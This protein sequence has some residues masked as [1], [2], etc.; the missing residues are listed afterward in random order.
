MTTTRTERGGPSPSQR[1]DSGQR[2][3]LSAVPPAELRPGPHGRAVELFDPVRQAV[4][5]QA[6]AA[7][8]IVGRA[9]R[10]AG[11][12][13]ATAYRLKERSPAFAEAWAEALTASVDDLEHVALERARDGSDSVLLRVLEAHRPERYSRKLDVKHAGT[14]DFV[15]DLVPMPASAD[16]GGDVLDTEAEVVGPGE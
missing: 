13:T 12:N 8:P 2:T 9:C 1:D 4:F 14:V 11:I 6:L 5:L 3:A 16:G 15:I 10:A 7:D